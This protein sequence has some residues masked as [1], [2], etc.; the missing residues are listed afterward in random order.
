[1]PIKVPSFLKWKIHENIEKS[2]SLWFS[3]T[4]LSIISQFWLA[5]MSKFSNIWRINFFSSRMLLQQRIRCFHEKHSMMHLFTVHGFLSTWNSW[6]T[7]LTMIIF[8]TLQ[9][10]LF[11]YRIKKI[12]RK[13]SKNERYEKTA[14][15]SCINS[16][17]INISL[18]KILN[19]QHFNYIPHPS[20]GLFQGNSWWREENNSLS[21]CFTFLI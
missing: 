20:V 13:K 19:C 12:T 10:K 15:F 11:P 4:W 16:F 14:A 18:I 17:S 6:F 7:H 2:Q 5:V 21:N 8:Y 9:M 1:M 3:F